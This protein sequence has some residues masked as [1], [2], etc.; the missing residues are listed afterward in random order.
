[1]ILEREEKFTSE[2]ADRVRHGLTKPDIRQQRGA[3]I[4]VMAC[5][6]RTII[7]GSRTIRHCTIKDLN[8]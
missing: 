3:I 2:G 4:V 8:P 1:M 6:I 5:I 7:P